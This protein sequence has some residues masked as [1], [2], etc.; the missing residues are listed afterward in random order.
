[1]KRK[2]AG[3]AQQWLDEYN[4]EKKKYFDAV[5]KAKTL[6]PAPPRC[7]SLTESDRGD[8]AKAEIEVLRR[9]WKHCFELFDKR[10]AGCHF[11][12]DDCRKSYLLDLAETGGKSIG[13]QTANQHGQGVFQA[14]DKSME[15]GGERQ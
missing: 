6:P 7:V 5:A 9:Q 15:S 1:M 4:A 2:P 13:Q 10:K 8:M 3:F 14:I 12:E 11:S